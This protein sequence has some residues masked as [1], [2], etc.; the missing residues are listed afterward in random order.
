MCVFGLGIFG[1][2]FGFI[3]NSDNDVEFSVGC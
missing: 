1:N 2:V 3:V